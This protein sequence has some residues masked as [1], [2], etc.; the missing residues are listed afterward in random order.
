MGI[1]LYEKNNFFKDQALDKLFKVQTSNKLLKA[2]TSKD[3]SQSAN[4]KQKF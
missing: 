1:Q 4:F 2:Q 3:L